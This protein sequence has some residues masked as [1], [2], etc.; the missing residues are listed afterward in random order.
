LRHLHDALLWDPEILGRT[1]EVVMA[2]ASA[3]LL[4]VGRVPRVRAFVLMVAAGPFLAGVAHRAEAATR[5]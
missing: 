4:P 5:A 1:V 2:V 3:H